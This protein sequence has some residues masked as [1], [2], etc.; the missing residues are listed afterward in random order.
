MT[1]ST[2]HTS[3]L[4]ISQWASPVGKRMLKGWSAC[5]AEKR[6]RCCSKQT[7]QHWDRTGRTGCLVDSG[8]GYAELNGYLWALPKCSI[9][10]F[11]SLSS[12]SRIV[13]SFFRWR[14]EST[15]RMMETFQMHWNIKFDYSDTF[16]NKLQW[17][18]ACRCW[19]SWRKNTPDSIYVHTLI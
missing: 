10:V 9:Q 1:S 5:G 17:T 3:Y 4:S 6:V 19:C 16:W 7:E 15:P 8:D 13:S 2:P 12:L 18:S 14:H 11:F